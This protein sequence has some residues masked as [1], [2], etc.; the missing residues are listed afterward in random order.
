M[1]PPPQDQRGLGYVNGTADLLRISVPLQGDGSA[2]VKVEA[3]AAD[4]AC[5]ALSK[6]TKQSGAAKRSA[7]T[8]KKSAPSAEDNNVVVEVRQDVS[9][10]A[11]SR[12]SYE[13][14]VTE[15]R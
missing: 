10:S 2:D 15:P 3:L 5:D 7:K 1:S 9:S 13:A 11:A 12:R 14:D 4:E 6:S 8:S